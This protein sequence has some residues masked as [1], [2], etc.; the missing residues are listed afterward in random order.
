[1]ML[2]AAVRAASRRTKLT[3][4]GP[5]SFVAGCAALSALLMGPRTAAA[6]ESVNRVRAAVT[7]PSHT[8]YPAP[9]FLNGLQLEFHGNS[10]TD[11][12]YA[13]YEPGPNRFTDKFNDFR[14]RFVLGADLDYG[15]G[16]NFYFHGRGQ[17]VDWIREPIGGPGGGNQYLV[18]A[19]DVYV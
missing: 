11:V 6:E 16:Q 2:E 18:N 12:G 17:L 4:L 10:E 19:D 15:F 13:K 1:S 14:G 3:R 9:S 7:D 8:P 5:A